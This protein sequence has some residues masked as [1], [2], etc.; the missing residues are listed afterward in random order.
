MNPIDAKKPLKI[1]GLLHYLAE[2]EGFEPSKSGTK[3][4]SGE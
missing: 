1:R 2:S 4:D 3:G